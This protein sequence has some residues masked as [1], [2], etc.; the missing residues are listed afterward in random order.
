MVELRHIAL[1]AVLAALLLPPVALHSAEPAD[2]GSEDDGGKAEAASEGAGSPPDS[3]RLFEA[4]LV[5]G[6]AEAVSRVPGSAHVITRDDLDRQQYS[7][8]HRILRQVPGVNIL[9]ED[10]YGLR[11]NIGIR[12]TGVDRSQKITLLEDGVLIAPAPYA[13]PSAY[14]SPT[15]GR[16]EGFEVRKGSSSIRQGPYTNGGALNYLST[17]IPGALAARVDLAAGDDAY[18]RAHAWAGDSGERYGWL[19]ESYRLSTDGFKRLDGGGATG[20]D[21]EDHLAKVRWSSRPGARTFQAVEIKAGKVEQ[22]GDETYLGLTREDFDRNPYRRYAASAGDNITTDHEQLQLS[23]FLQPSDRLSLTATVYDNAFFRNWFKLEKVGGTGVA[24]VLARPGEFAG[25]LAVLR[26]DADSAPGDLRVRHNRRSYSSRG[27]QA[28]LSWRLDR[29]ASTHELE[30][31]VRLHEDQEDR[32][33]EEDLFQMLD[34]RRVLNEIGIPGSQANR[35]AD[36]RALAFFVQDTLSSGRWTFTPGLRV[37]RIDLSRRDYGP[38]DP[39]RS[40]ADLQVRAN[41]LTEVIP[42]LGIA[43]AVGESSSLFLGIHRGFSPPGP[44]ST[45]GVDAEES[46]NYEL[47]W[48]HRDGDLSAEIIGFFN[49]YDNLLGNDTVS[50]G[51]GGTGDQFN[52][53]AVEVRGVEAAL[54]ID[55]ARGARLSAPLRLAYVYTA[56]EFRST[57]AT[58]FADWAPLVRRG[59]ELPYIAEHQLHAGVSLE[60]SRWGVHLDAS[61]SDEMRTRAGS[62]PIP[63]AESI[64]SHLVF[65]LRAEVRLSDGLRLWGQLLN[66]TDEVYVA[67]RRPAGLRPGRPRAALFGISYGFSGGA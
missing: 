53:G 67:A 31:G 49:D 23:Y 24:E 42:G 63:A 8:V 21:L 52:G 47:G 62:G 35:I 11:P 5:V 54:G 66:A 2:S 28:V 37:E 59:D 22:A 9:D 41:D 39:D 65:D 46:V 43:Y 29:A 10:G 60:G 7:D 1:R 32:F 44:G 19:V 51:G 12:G 34:G 15:A 16:M 14:Y 57:F 4:L 61:Y 48:R 50:T 6:E 58:S 45:S 30:L 40:G 3:T 13:A 26:G 33:Q 20:F 38:A 64:E 17:G 36:A 27:A 56:A 55:L 25:L 18:R